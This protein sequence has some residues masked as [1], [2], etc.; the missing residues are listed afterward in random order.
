MIKNT[1]FNIREDNLTSVVNNKK[2]SKS[3]LVEFTVKY[4]GKALDKNEIEADE[5]ATSLLGISTALEQANTILNGKESKSVIKVRSSFREGSFIVDMATFFSSDGI[6]AFVNAGSIV[7]F[8][9]GGKTL[10]WLFR[11]TKG[12]KILEKTQ[13]GDKCQIRVE[14]C[15]NPII[16]NADVITLYEN[17]SIREGLRNVSFPLENE[18]ISNIEFFKDEIVC[19]QI[20]REDRENFSPLDTETIDEKEDIDYFSITRP[21]FEGRPMGWRLSFGDTGD[22]PVK[23]LDNDFLRK[24]RNKTVKISNDEGTIIKAKYK[25][26]TQKHERLAVKWDILEVLE[27]DNTSNKRI[28]KFKRFF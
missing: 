2:W 18:G 4:N 9:A 11:Q 10:I 14:N 17:A 7:G 15:D 23:I 6:D 8:L 12:K 16:I 1:N 3:E 25:K 5:L 21:D 13:I 26:T 27:I 22:F 20:I 28:D 24:V 19:E